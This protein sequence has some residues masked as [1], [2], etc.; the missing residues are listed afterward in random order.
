M[1]HPSS[2]RIFWVDRRLEGLGVCAAPGGKAAILSSM[3]GTEGN[4]HCDRYS[5]GSGATLARG[6]GQNLR[7]RF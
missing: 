7:I 5:S 6:P 1:K 2:F 4:R 3:C